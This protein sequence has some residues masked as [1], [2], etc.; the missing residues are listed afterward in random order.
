[1]TIEISSDSDFELL[2]LYE[3][4]SDQFDWQ[5]FS[6]QIVKYKPKYF[7]PDKYNWAKDSWAIAKYAAQYFDISKL[8]HTR[9]FIYHKINKS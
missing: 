2:Q 3:F 8:V 1:M 6:Y 9:R 7:D 4:G 5:Y